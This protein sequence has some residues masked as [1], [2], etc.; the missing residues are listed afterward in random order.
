MGTPERAQALL[1]FD[2]ECGLCQ[3]LIR[4]LLARDS[5]GTLRFAPLQGPT[6][7]GHLRRLGLPTADW[8]SLVFLPS[9]EGD[10]AL[11]RT[12]GVVA[13]LLL[14]DRPWPFWGRCLRAVPR[15]VRDLG[16]KVVARL[17][18]ALFGEYRPKPL[19]R[20]EWAERILP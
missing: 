6:A 1:L 4:F 19:P 14:L 3:A 20:P 10:E 8:N 12:D 11:L 13:V 7:Q 17:R 16:Y 9:T 15:P 18:Y 5:R 2:G